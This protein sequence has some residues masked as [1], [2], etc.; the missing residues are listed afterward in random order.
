[1]S[2]RACANST[3]GLLGANLREGHGRLAVSRL[4][5]LVEQRVAVG[6]TPAFG[7]VS[8]QIHNAAGLGGRQLHGAAQVRLRS[9]IVFPALGYL[10]LFKLAFRRPLLGYAF[11]NGFRLVDSTA[12]KT[13]RVQVEREEIVFPFMV[14][15]VQG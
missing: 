4:T 14:G 6:Q 1:M 13:R 9:R 2:T 10:S 11:G 8:R 5:C 12:K 7:N 3:V 15:T